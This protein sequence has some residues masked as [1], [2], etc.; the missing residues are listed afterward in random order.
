LDREAMAREEWPPGL[1][2]F[3]NIKQGP[4][5]NVR[6]HWHRRGER[7]IQHD[8]LQ[9]RW[10]SPLRGKGMSHSQRRAQLVASEEGGQEGSI[11]ILFCLKT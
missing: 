7:I 9:N 5:K 3:L 10:C 1:G 6:G 11:A 2:F 4:D 8:K